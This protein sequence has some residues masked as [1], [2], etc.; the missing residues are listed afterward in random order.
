MRVLRTP[1][2][3]LHISRTRNDTR[4][5]HLSHCRRLRLFTRTRLLS[6]ASIVTSVLALPTQKWSDVREP[7]GVDDEECALCME[8]FGE[9]DEVRV[10]T[11]RHYF[12]TKCI[13]QWLVVA[14]QSKSRSCPLCQTA[15]LTG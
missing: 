3:A 1:T 7:S 8:A 9:S 13:D 14:Q 12:H 4:T 5:V 15:V 2:L 6:Q 11:C 10:L